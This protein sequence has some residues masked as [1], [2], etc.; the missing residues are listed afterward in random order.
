MGF[1]GRARRWIDIKIIQ[2]KLPQNMCSIQR[3][4]F[5]TRRDFW[6]VFGLIKQTKGINR[7]YASQ[8]RA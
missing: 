8:I 3:T 2:S 1:N 4:A 5:R 6:L 7:Y